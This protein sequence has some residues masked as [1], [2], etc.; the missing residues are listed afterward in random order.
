MLK[1]FGLLL[2]AM[3]FITTNIFSN[4]DKPSATEI[5][6]II[7]SAADT[8]DPQEAAVLYMQLNRNM[9]ILLKEQYEKTV[10][11]DIVNNTPLNENY[12]VELFGKFM[13]NI[14]D[15]MLEHCLELGVLQHTLPLE[16]RKALSDNLVATA[17]AFIISLNMHLEEKFSTIDFEKTEDKVAYL[18]FISEEMGNYLLEIIAT[19]ERT[20]AQFYPL[21]II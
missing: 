5:L 21:E 8:I 16:V 10:E 18:K 17:Q 9:T 3:Q 14:N 1:R 20:F 4:V 19:Q 13:K 7:S 12:S 15:A 2:V 11:Q 6:D